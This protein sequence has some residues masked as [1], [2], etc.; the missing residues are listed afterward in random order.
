M[1]LATARRRELRIA[2]LG[3]AIIIWG[4]PLLVH[5]QRGP[6]DEGWQ[7]TPGPASAVPPG[8]SAART[9]TTPA[10]VSRPRPNRAA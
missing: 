9:G 5:G 2:L 10:S 8:T 7:A 1:H 3:L 4:S 6:N